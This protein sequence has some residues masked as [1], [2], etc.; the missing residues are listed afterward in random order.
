ML[1]EEC[2]ADVLEDR[3]AAAGRAALLRE[4]PCERL[5][6]LDDRRHLALVARQHD[7]LGE[8]VGDDEHVL[9]CDRAQQDRA[10]RENLLVLV[11]CD[12]DGRALVLALRDGPDDALA[13]PAQDLVFLQHGHAEQHHHAIAEHGHHA[14]AAR[15][16]GERRGG[17]DVGALEARRVDAVAKQDGP[18]FAAHGG[19]RGGAHGGHA[20]RSIAPKRAGVAT[21]AKILNG[22]PRPKRSIQA[23]DIR[24]ITGPW[25]VAKPLSFE[26]RYVVKR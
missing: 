23:I 13:Q 18:H 22:L 26:S 1:H 2:I 6:H 19:R 4:L 15:P 11:R 17:K 8:R 3:D 7:T 24:V 14:V 16:K 20:T 10:A 21:I 9:G 12:L 25:M 5:D